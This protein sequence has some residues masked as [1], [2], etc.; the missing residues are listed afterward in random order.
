MNIFHCFIIPLLSLSDSSCIVIKMIILSVSDSSI[1]VLLLLDTSFWILSNNMFIT[2]SDITGENHYKG[3]D[4]L[5]WVVSFCKTFQWNSKI[6]ISLKNLKICLKNQLTCNESLMVLTD[7]F[8]ATAHHWCHSHHESHQKWAIAPN[9]SANT[10]R[11]S[12]QV[13]WFLKK[14]VFKF[15]DTTCE[16]K[17]PH[18][19]SRI[20][21]IMLNNT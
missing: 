8:R 1:W 10:E 12:W 20:S 11:L 14:I 17:L 16:K 2:Q 19:I 9:T 18:F 6:R 3:I 21:L 15:S 4:L 13:S 5:L 7:V